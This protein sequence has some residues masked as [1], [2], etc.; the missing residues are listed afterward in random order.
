MDGMMLG[1]VA[2]GINCNGSYD[3]SYVAYNLTGGRN[4]DFSIRTNRSIGPVQYNGLGVRRMMV[5]VSK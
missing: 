4:K 2:Y 3:T 5:G 1:R